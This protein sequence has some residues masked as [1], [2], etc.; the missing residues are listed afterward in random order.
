[1][2]ASEAIS[3]KV[4]YNPPAQ[5][6]LKTMTGTLLGAN[7]TYDGGN[8][9]DLSDYFSGSP[10]VFATP[11]DGYTFAHDAGTAAAGKLIAYVGVQN[12]INGAVANT[13]MTPVALNSDLSAVNT[14]FIAFGAPK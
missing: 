9:I 3:V 12:A 4:T 6:G 7:N 10:V 11:Q 14:T 5:S 2:A 13:P 1:M 8:T